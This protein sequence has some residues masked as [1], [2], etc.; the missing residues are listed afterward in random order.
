MKKLF[1]SLLSILMLISLFSGCSQQTKILFSR[2]FF[3]FVAKDG[4]LASQQT[5]AAFLPSGETQKT[6]DC[7]EHRVDG[8]RGVTVSY[9]L[10]FPKSHALFRNTLFSEKSAKG[11]QIPQILLNSTPAAFIL[12]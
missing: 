4:A 8:G 6:V 5:D 10:L 9:K 11:R 12:I 2:Q 1:F 7:G 3:F